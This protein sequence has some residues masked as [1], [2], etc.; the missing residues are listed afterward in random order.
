MTFKTGVI[1]VA[2]APALTIKT[3]TPRSKLDTIKVLPT[4]AIISTAKVIISLPFADDA[5]IRLIR[6]LTIWVASSALKWIRQIRTN[7]RL[8]CRR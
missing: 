3:L 5:D 4:R 8:S 6:P 2:K 1:A 7:A